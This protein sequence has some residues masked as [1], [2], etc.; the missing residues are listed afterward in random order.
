MLLFTLDLFLVDI[1]LKVGD[2]FFLMKYMNQKVDSHIRNY[3]F[4]MEPDIKRDVE[5]ATK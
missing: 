1:F 5:V 3:F 2:E 4:I